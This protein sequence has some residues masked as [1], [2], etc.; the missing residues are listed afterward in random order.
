MQ[1]LKGYS[2]Y[3]ISA[4]NPS[5]LI[6]F[7]ESKKQVLKYLGI[8]DFNNKISNL[9]KELKLR[10]NSKQHK[11]LMNNISSKFDTNAYKIVHITKNYLVIK[12]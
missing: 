10:K 4:H 5:E 2:I 6:E 8:Q 12:E 7:T 9:V 11:N 3:K 1:K